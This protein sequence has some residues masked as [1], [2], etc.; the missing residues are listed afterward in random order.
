MGD[1]KRKWDP[2]DISTE[3]LRTFGIDEKRFRKLTPK[4]QK[5]FLKLHALD[6]SILLR[7]RKKRPRPDPNAEYKTTFRQVL[8]YLWVPYRGLF[9]YTVV[10]S[11]VQALL[12]LGLPLMLQRAINI[13]LT[14]Q[15]LDLVYENIVLTVVLMIALAFVM[16]I[17]IYGN[18]WIGLNIIKDLRDAAYK[19]FQK[20]SF[21]FYDKH[22]TGDLISRTTSD[23]NLLRTL[24]SAEL[25]MFIRQ[26]LMIVFAIGGMFYINST[27]ATYAIIPMPI[28]FVIMIYFRRKIRPTFRKSRDK[29]GELTSQVQ[30]NITG[31]RVV[32]AFAQEDEEIKDFT[33]LNTSYNDINKKL[34]VYQSSF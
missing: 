14:T 34:K 22:N 5:S 3:D 32:R 21:E 7:D 18:H 15:D 26:S 6:D 17:R 30:E 2:K 33:N 28:A 31:M 1:K 24:L 10:L 19:K 23:I 12:F 29:Y 11:F 4:E 27:V 25:A 8:G 9:L 16:Y 20:A 13:L